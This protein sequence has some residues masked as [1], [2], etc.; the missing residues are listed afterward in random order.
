[1]ITAEERSRKEICRLFEEIVDQSMTEDEAIA[2]KKKV[3]DDLLV[4][5][6]ACE[7]SKEK[8]TVV[9][10][11]KKS[12]RAIS[13]KNMKYLRENCKLPYI[14]LVKSNAEDEETCYTLKRADM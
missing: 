2:F 13:S 6:Q 4:L 7:E 12:D 3:K 14:M 8:Q 10:S 9:N 5:L 1:M 11:I